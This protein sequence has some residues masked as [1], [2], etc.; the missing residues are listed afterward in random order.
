MP[1]HRVLDVGCG[2]LRGGFWLIHF[3]DRNRYFGIEPNEKMLEMG[4]KE[5]VPPDL[6]ADKVPR[7]DKNA[8]FNFGVF[9]EKFD[10]VLARS[11]WSH[12]APAQVEKMLDQFKMWSVPGAVFLT[13]YH[14]AEPSQEQYSGTTWVGRSHESDI[15]GLVR[16]RF[17]WMLDQ[18]AKRDL[19]VHEL[20]RNILDQIWLR[21]E[22]I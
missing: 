1:E 16:Y 10:F 17:E 14:R 7:F 4:I 21:V 19:V 8:E 6:I 22:H 13:S 20:K 2:C 11:I 5:F 15:G 9:S 18:C 3:L 12:A